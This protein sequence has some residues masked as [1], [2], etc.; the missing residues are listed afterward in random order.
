MNAGATTLG[1]LAGGRA[2]RLGGADKAWL[3][4]GGE[5]QV[6]RLAKRVR[7]E[8][9]AVLVSANR[10]LERYAA[11]GMAAVSDRRPDLGP[12]GGLDALAWACATP[13]LLTLPVDL[14]SVNDCLLRSLQAAGGDGAWAEDDD[15]R[16]PLVAL[17]RTAALRAALPAALDSGDL[18][19]RALQTRL[20]MVGVRF[21]GLR[22]GNLNTP[23]D[24][25]A[26]GLDAG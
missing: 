16:Q 25:A 5:P 7:G 9:D 14:V 18:S 22:F 23:A 17:W 21:A 2:T 19:A 1:L 6:L 8:V 3:E 15:G 11:H 13:W 20:D 24:L 12:L 10:D 26:A 4:K